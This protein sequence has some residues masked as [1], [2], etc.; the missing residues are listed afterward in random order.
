MVS[1][2]IGE[3]KGL[4]VDDPSRWETNADWLIQVT[5]FSTAMLLM[6]L[7]W[8]RTPSHGQLRLPEGVCL[9]PWGRRALSAVIDLV[10]GLW[11]AGSVYGLGWDVLLFE[12]WPGTPT[13]KPPAMML[14]G[15][16]VIAVT[17]GHTTV[18]ECLAARSLGK[19]CTGLYVAGFRGERAAP[20]AALLRSAMRVL[21]LIAWLLLL[22]PLISPCRQRLGDL[23]ART[24]VVMRKPEAPGEQDP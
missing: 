5:V 7:F 12:Y 23:L 2:G 15:V 8:R 1:G 17:V 10:P 21:D 14:P 18:F 22:L 11:I 19:W 6:L 16:V 3:A 4:W 24:V 13:P 9:A 20:G